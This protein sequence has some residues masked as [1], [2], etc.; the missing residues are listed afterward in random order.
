MNY[1]LL[2][3][4]WDG[5]LMD[6]AGRIVASLIQAFADIG[7]EPPARSAAAISSAWVW[8]RRC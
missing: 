5:T 6:S 1:Q 4:D 7:A 8:K 2:V 3:F